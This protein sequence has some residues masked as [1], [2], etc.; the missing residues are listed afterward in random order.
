[1]S[2]QR[3]DPDELLARVQDEEARA[4]RGKLKIFFGAAAG[5][6][7]T[8]AMLKAAQRER[9]EGVDVVVGYVET[10]GR[11]ETA[12]AAGRPGR[13]AARGWSPTGACCCGNSISMPRLARRPRL[14]LVDEL[15][16]TNAEGS[17]HAKRW[18]DVEELLDAGIDVY[19]HAQ[20]AAHREP[21]RRHRADHRCR[22]SAR[23]CPTPCSSRRTTSSSSISRPKSSLERLA[24]RQGLR[25]RAGRTA[26]ENF[27]QKGNLMALREMALRGSTAERSTWRCGP[28]STAARPLGDQRTAAGVRRAQPDHARL[29]RTAKR[30]ADA[31]SR[32]SGWPW[33]WNAARASGCPPPAS[34]SQHLRL[35][36]Q[37]GAETHT[38]IGERVARTIIDFARLRNVTKLVVG[39]TASPAGSVL[40]GTVVDELLDTSGEHRRLR[41][42]G[43]PE[44]AKAAPPPP[45]F[46]PRPP[47]AWPHYLATAVI[48][49]L[50]H[51]G[52]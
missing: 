50:C 1:M 26:L 38:L 5:V 12:G 22:A 46:S 35:A 48:V 41:H 27:F 8:Y 42:P 16:H 4:R 7:K 24:G 15:A 47:I 36:E 44:D 49:T 25:P 2:E 30:M 40:I 11:P 20:R 51:S 34:K 39:K 18:Q 43:A 23:R 14:I 37:L 17:R 9:A 3:P 28:G 6:G 29:I 31:I 13:T 33:P 32:R 10:H 21:E 19:T 52:G 45:P